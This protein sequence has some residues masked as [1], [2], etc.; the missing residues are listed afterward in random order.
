MFNFKIDD[1]TTWLYVLAYIRISRVSKAELTI[2]RQVRPSIKRYLLFRLD[3]CNL[4]RTDGAVRWKPSKRV[5]TGQSRLFLGQ[6]RKSQIKFRR[7]GRWMHLLFN[8]FSQ[9]PISVIN[10][11]L[12]CKLYICHMNFTYNNSSKIGITLC[13]AKFQGLIASEA[14]SVAFFEFMRPLL[15]LLYV[16]S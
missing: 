2:Q 7:F 5:H 14:F 16:I 6:L 10:C 15:Q 12:V 11:I 3:C 9:I 4:T 8:C 13:S 1:A